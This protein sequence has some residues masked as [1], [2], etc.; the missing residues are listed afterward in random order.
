[1]TVKAEQAA[2]QKFA[3]EHGFSQ[4]EQKI[5]AREHLRSSLTAP[6]FAGQVRGLVV[7]LS[8]LK[9][10]LNER[11]FLLYPK[12]AGEGICIVHV[13]IPKEGGNFLVSARSS[14]DGVFEL[15]SRRLNQG[16]PISGNI[17]RTKNSDFALPEDFSE[18]NFTHLRIVEGLIDE[19]Q[20]ELIRSFMKGNV[21]DLRFIR[22]IADDAPYNQRELNAAL[23]AFVDTAQKYPQEMESAHLVLGEMR[24]RRAIKDALAAYEDEHGFS[25]G[26]I[27][28]PLFSRVGST[29][30]L[31]F[32]CRILINEEPN[33]GKWSK[34]FEIMFR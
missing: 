12:E 15:G 31:N 18:G 22:S 23:A 10:E 26:K 34:R 8:G 1:M 3:I 33:E 24:E 4:E 32:D 25:L 29:M 14:L 9:K 21:R 13:L 19:L 28:W 27:R 6:E 30:R 7:S 20:L 16:D 2:Q 5:M 17:Q 11:R